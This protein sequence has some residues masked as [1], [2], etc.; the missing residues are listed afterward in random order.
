MPKMPDRT[1]KLREEIL[2]KLEDVTFPSKNGPI[3]LSR[4]E[5]P[6]ERISAFMTRLTKGFLRYF[7]PEFNYAQSKFEV[8][9]ITAQIFLDSSLSML[10]VGTEELT[11]GD[12]VIRIQ[13]QVN[14][15]SGFW[16]Y[17]F[18]DVTHYV[19]HHTPK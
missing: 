4:M 15:Y 9:R 6:A 8:N 11:R 3:E 13:R 2:S 17:I 7:Y 16:Y 18:Y 14:D 10:L 1:A 12:T 5:P 19:V